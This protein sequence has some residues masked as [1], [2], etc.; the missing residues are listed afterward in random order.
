[1]AS[2]TNAQSR[3]NNT[4]V[5]Q[6]RKGQ[7]SSKN[8]SSKEYLGIYSTRN[9][10]SKERSSQLKKH[11]NNYMTMNTKPSSNKEA[12]RDRLKES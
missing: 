5:Q 8:I 10:G 9:D 4:S 2:T 11:E 3:K 7:E 6:F 12:S 1:M